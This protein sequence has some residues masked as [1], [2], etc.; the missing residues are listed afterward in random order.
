MDIGCFHGR[1]RLWYE[2]R[3][4]TKSYVDNVTH[5]ELRYML[6]LIHVASKMRPQPP[7]HPLIAIIGATGT[8]KSQVN[9]M[10]LTW[11]V[12]LC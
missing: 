10:T 11:E 5:L 3:L 7:Q 9:C 12:H 8:G 4:K 6:R 1:C 2:Y